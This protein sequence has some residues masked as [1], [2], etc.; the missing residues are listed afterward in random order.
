MDC[1]MYAHYETGNYVGSD[2]ILDDR[3]YGKALDTIVKGL[4]PTAVYS[5]MKA[6]IR[7]TADGKRAIIGHRT[8]VMIGLI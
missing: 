2:V 3:E 5:K 4:L 8:R 1:A 7:F 6:F